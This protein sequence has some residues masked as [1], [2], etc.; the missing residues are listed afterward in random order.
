MKIAVLGCGNMGKAL[1]EGL[2]KSFG[3]QCSIIAY[4]TNLFALTGL[5][6]NIVIK[7]ISQWFSDANALPDAVIVAVKPGDVA[8]ALQMEKENSAAAMPLWISIA[9]GI[10]LSKLHSLLPENARFCRVMPNTPAM[11]GEGVSAFSLSES[12]HDRDIA[13]VQAILNSCGKSVMIPENYMDA[14]TG[15]SGSGPAYVFL[16]I[17]ALIEGGVAAGLPYAVARDCAIQTVIGASKMVANAPDHPA[18]LKMKVMSPA[19]TTAAGC[20]ALEQH[21][22]KHAVID[23]VCKATA[24]SAE[25]GSKD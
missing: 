25:L 13:L 6:N 23:A 12:C 4:D 15:L 7:N 22:F 10:P 21:A 19:G 17:E 11:I 9:A 8:S 2:Q 18:S 14:V 20:M 16:F 24:R 1:I 5:P 3:D